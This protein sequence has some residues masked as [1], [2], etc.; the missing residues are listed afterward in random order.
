MLL[1]ALNGNR[2]SGVIDLNSKQ[3]EK[4]FYRKLDFRCVLCSHN[5]V[6]LGEYYIKAVKK[7]VGVLMS[8]AFIWA[9]LEI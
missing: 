3:M 1:G 2:P 6:Y 8:T 5:K 7:S 4:C 9:L